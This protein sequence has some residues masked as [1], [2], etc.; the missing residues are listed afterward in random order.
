MVMDFFRVRKEY[1]SG[2]GSEGKGPFPSSIT[3]VVEW[4]TRES[5]L[6]SDQETETEPETVDGVLIILVIDTDAW[7]E[8]YVIL[9]V[10]RFV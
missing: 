2:G 1:G 8:V 3:A 5:A 4:R 6:G 10:L 7:V 9:K